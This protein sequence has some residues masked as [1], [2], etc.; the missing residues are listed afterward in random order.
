M[1]RPPA[2]T[3]IR[4]SYDI[5]MYLSTYPV[6][7]HTECFAG[8]VRTVTTSTA[9]YAPYN[10]PMPSSNTRSENTTTSSGICHGNPPPPRSHL[11]ASSSAAQPFASKPP[12]LEMVPHQVV[13]RFH[14][15]ATLSRA[16]SPH[17]SLPALFSSGTQPPAQRLR[18]Q[19]CERWRC[20]G[21]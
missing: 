16:T 18:Q 8:P 5:R 19:P 4:I 12:A 11:L 13:I 15:I 9:R 6:F 21:E 17:P 3:P 10:R 1:V 20:I 14:A 2:L 7:S